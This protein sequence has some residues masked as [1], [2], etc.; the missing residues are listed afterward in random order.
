MARTS[1]DSPEDALIVRMLDSDALDKVLGYIDD[2]A[3]IAVWLTCKTFNARRPAGK[4]TTSVHA[5]FATPA[6]LDWAVYIGLQPRMVLNALPEFM[7]AALTQSGVDQNAHQKAMGRLTAHA[8]TIVGFLV[9]PDR[10]VRCIALRALCNIEQPTLTAY[11]SDIVCMLTDTN[12]FVRFTA[13]Q[14]L[15]NVEEATLTAHTGTIERLLTNPYADPDEDA[16]WGALCMV[17]TKYSLGRM[18]PAAVKMACS[19]ITN[20]I[21]HAS[22]RVRSE[23]QDALLL[24]Q[25]KMQFHW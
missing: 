15:G 5:M 17:R 20:M 24:L 23:A 9:V 4:F 12:P 22:V 8:G 13:L 11:F 25:P 16:L 2:G 7:T 18:T 14:T 10:S 1:C 3:Y 6:M 19:A 21:D